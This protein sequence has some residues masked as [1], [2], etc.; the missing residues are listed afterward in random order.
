MLVRLFSTALV[1]CCWLPMPLCGALGHFFAGEAPRIDASGT[2]VYEVPAPN[3]DGYPCAGPIAYCGSYVRFAAFLLCMGLGSSAI[4][5]PGLGSL[6]TGE[7]FFSHLSPGIPWLGW[8]SR[9]QEQY[10]AHH[11][12]CYPTLEAAISA[13]P[14]EA[15]ALSPPAPA[16]VFLATLDAV[17]VSAPIIVKH[18]LKVAKWPSLIGRYGFLNG[19]LFCDRM[20]RMCVFADDQFFSMQMILCPGRG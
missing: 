13:I 8:G 5:P 3:L 7:C 16:E 11:L 18:P 14:C 15:E 17:V 12:R 2:V 10:G 20:Q 9:S 1:V 19:H 6:L 4:A